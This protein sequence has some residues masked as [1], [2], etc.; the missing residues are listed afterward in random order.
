MANKRS[1]LTSCWNM[2]DAAADVQRYIRRAQ[3]CAPFGT[4]G[5]WL[6]YHLLQKAQKK[7]TAVEPLFELLE[8]QIE[9]DAQFRDFSI[10][11]TSNQKLAAFVFGKMIVSPSFVSTALLSDM[12][13]RISKITNRM[14]RIADILEQT[15]I[16]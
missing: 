7:L 6:A 12:S 1:L 14:R 5:R 9:R 16:G 2:I 11:S 10:G 4:V 15:Y 13:A 8:T 3:F